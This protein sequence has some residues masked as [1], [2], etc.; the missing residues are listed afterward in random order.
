M[1]SLVLQ[2][3]KKRQLTQYAVAEELGITPAALSRIERGITSPRPQL[4]ERIAEYYNLP[5]A[6]LKADF[7]QQR[8]ATTNRQNPPAAEQPQNILTMSSM[9]EALVESYRH[10]LAAARQFGKSVSDTVQIPIIGETA[11]GY[12]FEASMDNTGSTV[13]LPREMLRDTPGSYFALKVRGQSMEPELRDGD[14]AIIHQ[15]TT[16]NNGEI[17]LVVYGDDMS[18]IG[19]YGTLKRVNVSPGQIM[20]IPINPEYETVTIAGDDLGSVQI[21]GRLVH[22]LRSY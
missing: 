6:D 5:L 12:G 2:E 16:L 4:M 1:S 8:K 19:T 18:S 14:T 3:R 15:Q 20:L 10:G 9:E 7:A 17:G 21:Q 13:T 22:V 11:A